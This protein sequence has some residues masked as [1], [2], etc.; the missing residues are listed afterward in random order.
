MNKNATVV[1][2]SVIAAVLA[3][4]AV[5]VTMPNAYAAR[6]GTSGANQN[7]NGGD[8]NGGQGGNANGGSGGNCNGNAN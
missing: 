1:M 2:S 7:A 3:L 4:G 6:V 8:A 5:S